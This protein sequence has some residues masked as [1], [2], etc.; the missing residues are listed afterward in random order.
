M[1]ED[2]V[3]SFL[4]SFRTRRA[5]GARRIFLLRQVK[6]LADWMRLFRLS[7]RKTGILLGLFH[8]NGR[9]GIPYSKSHITHVR[10]G[11]RQLT[12]DALRALAAATNAL[13]DQQTGGLF[14]VKMKF[15]PEWFVLISRRCSK[16][17]RRYFQPKRVNQ[18][19]CPRCRK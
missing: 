3:T 7:S 12:P 4:T 18:K 17:E 5:P 11:G 9:R 10:G 15:S 6:C 8:P 14:K 1:T 16:C 2:E 13:L 19:V